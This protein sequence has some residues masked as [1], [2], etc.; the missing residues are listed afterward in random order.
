M[1]AQLRRTLIALIASFSVTLLIASMAGAHII[2]KSI[3]VETESGVGECVG[4]GVTASGEACGA[5]VYGPDGFTGTL[6]FSAD[7]IG[8]TL[9]VVDYICVHTTSE[10]PFVAY[11][12][13]A[14]Y[15]LKLFEGATLL[16]QG[17]YAVTDGQECKSDNNAVVGAFTT[18]GV[19]ITV[20]ADG[21]VTY[22][23]KIAGLEPGATVEAAFS[24]YN[25]IRNRALDSQG[26]HADSESVK[27]PTLFIIPEAPLTVLLVLTGGLTAAWFVSRKMRVRRPSVA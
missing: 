13:G 27:P 26:G 20:P 4:S 2:H 9:K 8:D 24:D 11:S 3:L 12:M 22:A 5:A 18:A 16:G 1:R 21:T 10:G 25:S 14:T 17:T 23:V 19:Q 7:E 15:T 6:T